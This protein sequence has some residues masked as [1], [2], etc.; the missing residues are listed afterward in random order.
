MCVYLPT[1]ELPFPVERVYDRL[2]TRTQLSHRY[3]QLTGQLGFALRLYLPG[4]VSHWL[5]S[6]VMGGAACHSARALISVT[7]SFGLT[8]VPAG[9]AISIVGEKQ[10]EVPGRETE[11]PAGGAGIVRSVETL[12]WGTSLQTCL[13]DSL[14]RKR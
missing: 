3:I 1:L 7:R 11:E 6:A 10:L 4:S 9:V 14:A 5:T 2:I 13:K 12:Q 8:L